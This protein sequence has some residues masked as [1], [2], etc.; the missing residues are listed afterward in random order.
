[1]I[2]MIRFIKEIGIIKLM[3][4]TISITYSNYTNS[5]I[6]IKVSI[7]IK[8]QDKLNNIRIYTYIYSCS[9]HS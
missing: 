5:N 1:M 2:L 7:I 9:N 3:T 8:M 6:L 4:T